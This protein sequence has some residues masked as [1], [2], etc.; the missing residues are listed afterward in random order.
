MGKYKRFDELDHKV[1]PTR[2]AEIRKEALAELDQM[3]YAALRRA[4][5]LTQVEIAGRLGITQSSVAALEARTDLQ[6]STLGKYIR[7]M[8]GYL[9]MQAVFPEATFNLE[10]L[11]PAT[12]T[13]GVKSVRS[14][15]AA[16]GKPVTSTTTRSTKRRA[17]IAG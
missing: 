3:G 9:Q 4:R 10:P 2:R 16:K 8:G 15:P 11:P 14:K 13:V 1:S 17:A 12:K 5:E 7:A 6:I